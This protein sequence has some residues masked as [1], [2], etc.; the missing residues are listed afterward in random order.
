MADGAIRVRSSFRLARVRPDDTPGFR[1]TKVDGEAELD[2]LTGR[3]EGLQERL[4]AD[5]HHAVLIVLQG[6][7]TA[8]KDGTIRKVF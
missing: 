5:H 3:L 7:D 6:M 2:R 8:G 1:G 4:Y